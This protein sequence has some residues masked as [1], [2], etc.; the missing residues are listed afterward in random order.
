MTK[1]EIIERV[2]EGVEGINKKQAAEYVETMLNLLKETLVSGE[3]VK[4]SGL[5][6][7]VVRQKYPR[8]GR[9]PITGEPL[10]I[11]ERRVVNFKPSAILKNAMNDASQSK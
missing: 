5:G 8:L 7:F 11:P 10:S 1:A 6:N 9:N 2:Y 3:M 4:I